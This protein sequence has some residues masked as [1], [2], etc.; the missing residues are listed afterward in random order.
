[1]ETPQEVKKDIDVLGL[2]YIDYANS[3]AR[4]TQALKSLGLNVQTFC[5]R[6]LNLGYIDPNYPYPVGFSRELSNVVQDIPYII[7][8]PPRGMIQHLVDRSKIVWFFHS[9]MVQNIALPENKRYI[10]QHGGQTYRNDPQRCNGVFNPIVESTILQCPDLLNLGANNEHLV[11]YPVDINHIEPT[12]DFVDDDH[13]VIG[14]FPSSPVNK[15]TSTIV[16]V[17][18]RLMER[19]DE[20]KNKFIYSGIRPPKANNTSTFTHFVSWKDNLRRQAT[21]DVMIE[22]CNPMVGGKKFAEWGNTALECAAAG[23]LVVTNTLTRRLYI[24]EYGDEY[25][26]FLN[27]ATESGLEANLIEILNMD[28]GDLMKRKVATLNWVKNKHT[29]QRVGERLNDKLQLI[30]PVL[31][32]S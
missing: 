3:A 30:S 5:G 8:V 2:C 16:R 7:N 11:Y 28:R 10:V 29:I 9:T 24:E 32:G 13:I 1:M 4:F 18:D 6:R 27:N 22:T 17:I 12:L 19:K 31:S 21:A 25:P 15:G 14:H 20:F 26:L 23:K